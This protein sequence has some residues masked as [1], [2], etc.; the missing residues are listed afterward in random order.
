MCVCVATQISAQTLSD[1][2]PSARGGN[3]TAQ[4]NAAQC[5]RLGLGTEQNPTEWLHY[6]RL[7]AE[8]GEPRAQRELSDHYRS[9]APELASYWATGGNANPNYHYRSFDDG[10]YYGELLGGMRDGYGVYVWDNGTHYIGAWESGERHGMGVTYFDNQTIYGDHHQGQMGGYGAI[11]ITV[12]GC[13]LTGAEGSVYYVG[14]FE[15]GLPNGTGTLYDAEGKITYYGNFKNGLP[16]S[17]YPSN[18]SYNSYRW[19]HESLSNG[20]SWEGECFE[21]IRQGFGIYRWADGSWW[22]GYWH[23]GLRE[24]VGLFVRSDGVF[25]TGT[26]EN[27][28]FEN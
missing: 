20:D 25:T 13:W 6:L 7:S 14:Y 18:E 9:F 17:T 19:S 22:C 28:E 27:G 10:C 26:W 1:Y 11:V 23:E 21:G 12:E 5:Y 15:G 2:L 24:G 16:T 8:G 3:P 4:F